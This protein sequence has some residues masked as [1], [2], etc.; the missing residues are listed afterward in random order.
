MCALAV[1]FSGAEP[2]KLTKARERDPSTSLR[3]GSSA[4]GIMRLSRVFVNRKSTHLIIEKVP[5]W[6]VG[7]NKLIVR[8]VPI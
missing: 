7:Y 6:D 1:R 3:A 4:V 8:K 5:T 2:A